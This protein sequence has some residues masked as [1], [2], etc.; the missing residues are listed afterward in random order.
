MSDKPSSGKAPS[1]GGLSTRSVLA[2]VIGIVALL[3]IV[4]NR[5]HTQVSFIL[6]TAS[7][8]LWLALGLVA[9]FGFGA[10]YLFARR[11]DKG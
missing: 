3:F 2:I 10:G 9:G 11:R 6:F 8:P 5:D 4:L 1:S 7:A